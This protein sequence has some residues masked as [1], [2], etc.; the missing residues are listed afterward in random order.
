M[1]GDVILAGM[2]AAWLAV[3]AVPLALERVDAWRDRRLAEIRAAE[4]Q[5]NAAL[6][7]AIATLRRE[8]AQ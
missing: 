6:D 7:R 1:S 5:A 8:R 2:V 3:P 4:R